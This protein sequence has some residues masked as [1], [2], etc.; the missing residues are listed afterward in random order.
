MYVQLTTWLAI[1]ALY[2][3]FS[4]VMGILVRRSRTRSGSDW[5][6][7]LMLL[8]G[9]GL[10]LPASILVIGST[11]SPL[12]LRIFVTLSG[13]LLLGL[14]VEQPDWLPTALFQTGFL[15]RYF[16]GSML[17]ACLWGFASALTTHAVSALIIGMCAIVAGAAS[18]TAPGR[19]A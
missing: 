10:Y 9:F 8:H 2:L 3:G 5:G 18:L 19:A 1:A 6:Y 4:M 17:L 16:A 12:V 13:F 11:G 14:A 7:A 15:Y